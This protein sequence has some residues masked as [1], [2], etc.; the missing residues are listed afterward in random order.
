MFKDRTLWQDSRENQL[1]RS[2]ALEKLWPYGHSSIGELTFESAAYVARYIVKKQ[3]GPSAR[4]YYEYIDY[5]GEIH[6]RVPPYTTM[7]RRPGIGKGWYDSF[8]NDLYPSD[9]VI[10]TGGKKATVP[11]YY[12]GLEEKANPHRLASTKKRRKTRAKKHEHNNTYERR[13]IREYIQK[14][15]AQKLFRSME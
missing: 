6:D 11:K 5:N 8:S 9:F 7:S 14:R 3:A 12:D 13:V 10:T 1:Y 2:E 15:K 4:E